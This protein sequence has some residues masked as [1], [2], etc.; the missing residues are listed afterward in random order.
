MS[1]PTDLPRKK[2]LHLFQGYGV[3]LEYMIVDQAT[4]AIRSMADTVLAAAA[5]QP[6]IREVD[7]GALAWSNELVLHVIELKTNGPVAGLDGLETFFQQDVARINAMLAADGACLMPTAMHPFVNPDAE[8]QLWQHEGAE[9]YSALDRVF[10]CHGHGWKNLQSVHLNLPFDGDD[11]FVRLHEAIRRV[12]PLIPAIAASSPFQDGR[13]TGI[14]DNRLIA[15]QDHCRRFPQAM[16]PVVPEPVDSI[17]AYHDTV[18]APIY[19]ALRPHDLDGVLAYEWIN[20]RGAIARFERNTIEIRLTDV[21]ECP[22]ADIAIV[23]T[24]SEILRRLTEQPVRVG[25]APLA[26]ERLREILMR[27]VAQGQQA[28]IDD[29]DYLRSLGIGASS[30]TAGQ[31]WQTL[32]ESVTSLTAAQRGAIDLI[33]EHGTLA[34]RMKKRVPTVTPDSLRQLCRALADCLA[35]GTLLL[36]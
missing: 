7:C 9:I 8:A 31:V 3:E 20:A 13:A 23:K 17:Q 33:I 16:G 19:A 34:A 21:Q 6:F 4:F 29:T 35:Q 24:L 25:A 15:Y 18:L 26:S 12:L 1:L 2:P 27:T 10:G 22:L 28:M 36:P 14:L 11:E 30:M 32:A 5:G